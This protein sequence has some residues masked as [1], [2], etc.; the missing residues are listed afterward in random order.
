MDPIK[1]YEYRA[2]GLPVLSTS[3]GEMALRGRGDGVYFLDRG[4]DLAAAV[5]AALRH[6]YDMAEIDRFQ[7]DN[8]WTSRFEQSVGFRSLWP[9]SWI[10][11][12]A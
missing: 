5:A 11:R 12:A 9:A 2:A 1:Y 3:F 10:R 4:D 6:R 8:N 7:H